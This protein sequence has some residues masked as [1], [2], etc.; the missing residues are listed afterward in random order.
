MI[1]DERIVSATNRIAARGFGIGYV[2]SLLALLYRQFYL[3]QPVQEYWDMA[4]IFFV[5]TSYVTLASIAQGGV[6]ETALVRYG[7][8][9]A[10]VI[11]LTIL[12]VM[13]F[14]GQI[15]SVA[16]LAASA[17]SALAGLAL[18]GFVF[19]ALYRRWEK[20]SGLD[21]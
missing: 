12:A 15:R 9:T 19:Y 13:V 6:H 7:K 3:G 2:L 8:R 18:V 10:P 17:I 21:A 20:R 14:R 16:D 5:V 11:L 1:R 4:L